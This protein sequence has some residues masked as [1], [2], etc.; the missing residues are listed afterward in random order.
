MMHDGPEVVSIGVEGGTYRP[1]EDMWSPLQ[2]EWV[3]SA[4]WVPSVRRKGE[5]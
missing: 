4:K 5:E 3:I 2:G 1:T